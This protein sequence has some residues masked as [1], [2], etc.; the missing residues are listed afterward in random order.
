MKAKELGDKLIVAV[1][2]DR[3][4]SLLKGEARPINNLSHRMDVLKGLYSVDWL[5]S[6]DEDTP[7]ALIKR[8]KPDVLVKGSDYKINEIAG[9]D[10]VLKNGG[11]VITIDLIKGVSSSNI[12]NKKKT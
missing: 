1:N 4:V 9:A 10:Y 2:T 5:I 11:K 3:S 12:I 6:F 8:I 7:E